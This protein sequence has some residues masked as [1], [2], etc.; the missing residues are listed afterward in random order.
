M[1]VKKTVKKLLSKKEMIVAV[2]KDVIKLMR[3][4]KVSHSGNYCRSDEMSM[5]KRVL[6]AADEADAKKL[7]KL[8]PIMAKNCEV[9]ARGAMFLGHMHLYDGVDVIPDDSTASKESVKAFGRMVYD[10][11]GAFESAEVSRYP[12]PNL[13][14]N[15]LNN[16]DAPARLK[17]IMKN[18]IANE[19]VFK[20]EQLV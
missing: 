8:V 11:E 17:K 15:K 4:M 16:L 10:I 12:K 9:C 3:Y 6:K 19:G 2:A 14:L 1:P 13:C 20:P 5:D 7:Q 18:L